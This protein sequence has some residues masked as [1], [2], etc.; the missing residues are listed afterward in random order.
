MTTLN[1]KAVAAVLANK[2]DAFVRELLE[3]RRKGAR[4]SA[5]KYARMLM[6]ASDEDDRMRGTLR[7]HGGGP[8][9]WVGLGPQLQNLDRNDLGVPLSAPEPVRAGDRAHLAQYGNPLTL[10]GSLAR[11]ALCAAPGHELLDFDYAS[12]ESRV[13]ARLAGESWKISAYQQFD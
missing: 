13:L 5:R 1:K 4:A 9:R 11:G 3:L 6:F 10:I 8:G 2:P 12:V 7:W